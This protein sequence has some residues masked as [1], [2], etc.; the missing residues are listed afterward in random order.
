M[1]LNKRKSTNKKGSSKL[2]KHDYGLSANQKREMLDKRPTTRKGRAKWD[3]KQRERKE[4]E[5]DVILGIIEDDIDTTLGEISPRS[6][7]RK[8]L[9]KE[10]AERIREQ[11]SKKDFTADSVKEWRSRY[12]IGTKASVYIRPADKKGIEVYHN[13]LHRS[14]ESDERLNPVSDVIKRI[15]LYVALQKELRDVHFDKGRYLILSYDQEKIKGKQRPFL[16]M[17]R[18]NDKNEIAY[19]QGAWPLKYLKNKMDRTVPLGY[20][21]NIDELKYIEIKLDVINEGPKYVEYMYEDISL[22]G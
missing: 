7:I 9:D 5:I 6:P 16:L 14:T 4:K 2:T 11:T 12:G 1:S 10:M 15:D 13:F 21:A 20:K 19:L 3:K 18:V 8:V 17:A 22:V